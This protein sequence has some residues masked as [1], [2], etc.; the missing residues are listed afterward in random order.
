MK[1]VMKIGFDA[2]RAF[3]NSSGLGN[4]SR[5]TLNALRKYF[6][7]NSYQ[8]FTPEI[9]DKLFKN[10]KKFQVFSPRGFIAKNINPLWRSVLLLSQ[11]KRND[12]ELFHGLSNELPK[13]IDKS[14]IPAVVTI[15][16][17]I[18]MRYPEFYNII[19]R[20]I[21]FKK[22]RNACHAATKI[23]AISRQTKQDIVTFLQIPPEKIE[24]IY[25]PVSSVFFEKQNTDEALKIYDLPGDFILSVGTLEPRKNQLSILRALHAQ[26]IKTK[27]VFVGKQNAPYFKEMM[28]FIAEHEMSKQVMFLSDLPEEEL[29]ALYRAALFSVYISVFEGFGLPVIEAM[30]SR[31]PVITSTVSV[32]SETAGDA[33][34]LCNPAQIED[35]GEKLKILTESR[36]LRDTLIQKGKK[37]A[38]QFHPEIYARQLISLYTEIVNA[39]HAK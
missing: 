23:I 24:L 31:C 10:H 3:L 39:E 27:I 11:L 36:E 22:V 17:L 14:K 38:E 7:G 8:L 33:A 25:Q 29:A 30:A 15:H 21:Y 2:K 13:G 37:R 20:K 28:Q 32:L 26:K 1:Q 18:F 6:P 9:T 5:N 12:V 34:L 19:D 4:Y 16:D 35:I